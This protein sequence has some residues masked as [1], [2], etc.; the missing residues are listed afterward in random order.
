MLT[1]EHPNGA[2]GRDPMLA[3]LESAERHAE[4]LRASLPRD[5][6]R[7]G[8]PPSSDRIGTL[9]SPRL[10]PVKSL[11]GELVREGSRNHPPVSTS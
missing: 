6:K 11:K 5:P 2:V 10:R 8:R 4:R 9:S 1:I 7:P 3:V